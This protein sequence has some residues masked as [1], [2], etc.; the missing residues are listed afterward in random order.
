MWRKKLVKRVGWYRP[1][2]CIGFF[3][4]TP[5]G[6]L[7]KRIGKVLEEE[8]RRIGMELRSKERS[9]VS[10]TQHLVRADLRAWWRRRVAHCRCWRAWWWRCLDQIP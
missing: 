9:G 3:P 10:L 2:D 4:A 5:G 6:E 7:N 1:A 8:G